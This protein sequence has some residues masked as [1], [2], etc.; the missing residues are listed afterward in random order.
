VLHQA[1]HGGLALDAMILAHIK[2][3]ERRRRLVAALQAT[4]VPWSVPGFELLLR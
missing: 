4:C 3:V 2:D 1:H